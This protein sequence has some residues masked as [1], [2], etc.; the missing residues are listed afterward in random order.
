[1]LA[2]GLAVERCGFQVHR[3]IMMMALC[4]QNRCPLLLFSVKNSLIRLKF[5]D[6]P[7]CNFISLTVCIGVGL[8]SRSR[9]RLAL[10]SNLNTSLGTLH[11]LVIA[12]LTRG[13]TRNRPTAVDNLTRDS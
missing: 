12:L 4:S 9:G 1:M 2:A 11:M 8:V 5:V 7:T 3:E 6:L 13:E 10:A